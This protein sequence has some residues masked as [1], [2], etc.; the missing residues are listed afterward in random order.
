M[1]VNAQ[2]SAL[3]SVELGT[4]RK[5]S[6]N[7][8]VGGTFVCVCVCGCVCVCVCVCVCRGMGTCGPVK[9]CPHVTTFVVIPTKRQL[10]CELLLSTSPSLT[11]SC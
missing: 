3:L 2:I 1:I 4:I 5:L 7:F 6:G 9:I 11:G 10:S 8:N